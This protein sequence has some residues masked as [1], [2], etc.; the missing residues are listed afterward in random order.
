MTWDPLYLLKAVVFVRKFKK[1]GLWKI[2]KF[3]KILG[4]TKDG[5]NKGPWGFLGSCNVVYLRLCDI[6]LLEKSEP[7]RPE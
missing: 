5:S 4:V 6:Q 2:S 3:D 7:K 1:I